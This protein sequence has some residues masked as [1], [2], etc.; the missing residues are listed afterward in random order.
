MFSFALCVLLPVLALAVYLYRYAADQYASTVGFTV[1]TE[2]TG[3]AMDILGGLTSFSSA[4][5]S[6][7]DILYKFIQSQELVR[8]MDTT[9]DLRSLYRKPQTDPVFTLAPDASIEDLVTY[10]TRMVRIYYDPGTGLM[11]IE[12]RAFDPADARAISAEIFARSTRMIN[13]LSAIARDD[14]TRYA[15]EELNAAMARLKSARTALT[16]FRNQT[17][18]VDPMADLQGQMGLLS[19]LNSQLASAWIDVDMLTDTTRESDPRIEQARRK[20]A[21][22][23]KRITQEREKLGVGTNPDGRAYADLVGQFEV[24]QVDLSFAEKAYVSA[25]SAY[26]GAVAEARR[27]SRYLAAYIEPTLAETP[28]YPQRAIL[29]SIAAFV[30]FGLWSVLVLI[31]YSLRDRR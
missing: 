16:A 8:E 28:L 13:T 1:R 7:T 26:D 11:E 31:Y 2:E 6:D 4:S 9:L 3:S 17:Q 19:S 14:T 21:V 20:I 10:W 15:L 25:L 27:Q 30:L 5:S 12:A 29:L 18:I 23:E 22:I 24:L